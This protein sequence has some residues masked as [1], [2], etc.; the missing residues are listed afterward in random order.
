MLF[1]VVQPSTECNEAELKRLFGSNNKVIE[2]KDC[3]KVKFKGFI[4]GENLTECK[5]K[6]EQLNKKQD[7]PLR[8]YGLP[9][10]N[11]GEIIYLRRN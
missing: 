1:A 10:S 5:S 2:K 6:I 11:K 7:T 9:F 4:E 8:L 3:D